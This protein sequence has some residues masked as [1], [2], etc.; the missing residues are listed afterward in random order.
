MA[1]EV[2]S[3]RTENARLAEGLKTLATNS[4]QLTQEIRDNRALAPNAIFSD[5]VSNRI[6]TAILASRPTFLGFGGDKSAT[7]KSILATDGQTT[8]ALCHVE[9]TL[10]ALRD[11]G[12]DW[13]QLSGTLT[14]RGGS[15]TI[16]S[17]AFD[18]QDPRA[19]MIPLSPDEARQL[20]N[21]IYRLSSDPY[22][23]QD[24]VLVGANEVVIMANAISRL[25]WKR[26]I[27]SNWIAAC[28]AGCSENS[29]R[30]AAIWF[31]A[32]RANC[33]ASW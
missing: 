15:T 31:S 17:V 24:A 23:F 16:H 32:A 4:S 22:K 26:R 11:P 29:I 33:W 10:L 27:T 8:F 9:D 3:A 30:R 1:Q 14:G 20:G 25:I 19:V 13:N 21:K 5:F 28:C 18:Q 2:E 12:T 6:D 7:A